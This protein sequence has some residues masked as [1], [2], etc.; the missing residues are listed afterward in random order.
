MECTYVDD[1]KDV[2]HAKKWGHTHIDELVAYLPKI[3]SEKIILIHLSSRYSLEK[4][5]DCLKKK[6]PANELE[7]FILFPG[8]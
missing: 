3:Q 6:I 4:A 5:W 1:I 8:R 7:R 2:A